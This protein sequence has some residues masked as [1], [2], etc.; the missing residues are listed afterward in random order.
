MSLVEGIHVS[1]QIGNFNPNELNPILNAMQCL[2]NGD[3][4]ALP[5]FLGEPIEEEV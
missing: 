1:F 3:L 5:C 2:R 4:D